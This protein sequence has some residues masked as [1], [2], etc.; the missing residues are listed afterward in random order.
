MI[1]ALAGLA[2]RFWFAFPIIGLGIALLITR[3]TL[4]DVKD[5]LHKLQQ[6]TAQVLL[7]I[8]EVADNPR[9]KWVDAGKQVRAVGDA[10]DQWKRTS[11]A[12]TA[13]V[14]AME[15]ETARMRKVA[16][17]RQREIASLVRQRDRLATELAS[18]RATN[19]LQAQEELRHVEE[20]LDS[21]FAAGL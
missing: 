14:E 13:A 4:A 17:A 2:A 20:A 18:N 8:R 16:E 21:V 5:E 7:V 15:A 19:R 12:Q 3:G 6:E 10:R 9:L 11:D 1:G